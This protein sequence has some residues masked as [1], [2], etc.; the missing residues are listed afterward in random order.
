M[1]KKKKNAGP[2]NY[3]PCPLRPLQRISYSICHRCGKYDDCQARED[4]EMAVMMARETASDQ[5]DK[6]GSL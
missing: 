2:G 3:V 6:H 1:P 4:H 5:V